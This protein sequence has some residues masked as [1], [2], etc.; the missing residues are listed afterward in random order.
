MSRLNSEA[1]GVQWSTSDMHFEPNHEVSFH[2]PNGADMKYI[3]TSVLDF[4]CRFFSCLN[5]D[6]QGTFFCITENIKGFALILA[7]ISTF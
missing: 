3:Y 4:F 6:K 7:E 2:L 1:S 5:Y